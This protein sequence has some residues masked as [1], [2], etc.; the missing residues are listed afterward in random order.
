MNQNP[1][2]LCLDIAMRNIGAAILQWNTV[3]L[4]FV[5][6]SVLVTDA[7]TKEDRK[8]HTKASLY[9]KD[10]AYLY[11]QLHKLVAG[12]EIGLIAGELP[13][14]AQS[15]SAAMCLGVCWGLMGS[16]I[17]SFDNIPYVWVTPTEVKKA[18][19]SKKTATKEEMMN[20]AGFLYPDSLV[21]F[22]RHGKLLNRYEHVADA[23]GVSLAIRQTTE[24]K[25]YVAL[26]EAISKKT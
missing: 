6:G 10:S 12:K 26:C 7:A 25:H 13:L 24:F 2:I 19:C 11:E 4:D 20:C 3:A 16:L 8:E 5:S 15:A 18:M 21:P 14:G 22:M 17:A 1:C 23:I 9:V